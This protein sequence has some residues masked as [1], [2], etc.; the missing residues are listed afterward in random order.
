MHELASSHCKRFER[1]ASEVAAGFGGQGE[2]EGG[3]FAGGA[4]GPDAAAV[5][6][7]DAAAD[8]EAE[9]GAAHGAGVG[10]VALLEA[11]EDVFELVGGD[12]A[13]LVADLDEGF[14]VRRGCVAVRW[15]SLPGGEN[16]MAL[17]MRLV[18]VWRMRSGSAQTLTPL[19]VEEDADVGA[20]ACGSAAGWRRGGGGLRRSTW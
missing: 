1:A 6:G 14:V 16:L 20:G 12:A 13:A 19:A 18:R 9:A 5:L 7:D 11:V 3:A 17:E 8:G 15:I 10:G 2:V 4:G